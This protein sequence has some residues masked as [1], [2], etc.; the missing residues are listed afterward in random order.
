[1]TK[2]EIRE[3]EKQLLIVFDQTCKEAL[4]R[5]SEDSSRSFANALETLQGTLW[6]LHRMEQ[7][8]KRKAPVNIVG[9]TE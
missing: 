9:I 6:S 7:E 5:S 2:K 1:M 3:C 4:I 8:M